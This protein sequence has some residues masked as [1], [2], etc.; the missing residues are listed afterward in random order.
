MSRVIVTDSSGKPILDR[1]HNFIA[2]SAP[3]VTDDASKGYS[4]GSQWIDQTAD[5]AYQCVDATT[6]AAVW[7]DLSSGGGGGEANTASNVG[8]TGTG[9]YD[10]KSGV[11][12]RFRKLNALSSKL[13]IAADA[14]NQKVD[15]DLGTV[16]FSDLSTK[17][18]THADA[19][20]GGTLDGAAIGAGTVAA[21]RLG[22]MTGD[23]GAGGA[24]G[25]V[26]APAAGDAA[27]GKYLKA[28][29]TWA[30]V[31]ATATQVDRSSGAAGDYVA[32]V[33]LTADSN[34]RLSTGLDGSSNPI[35]QLGAGGAS[36]LDLQLKRTAAKTLTLDD[37]A[38]GAATLTIA[39]TGTINFGGA[40]LLDV[41]N[42]K[43]RFPVASS[44]L[45]ATEGYIQ[46]RSDVDRVD[47]YDGQR[48]RSVTSRGYA[49]FAYP[50]VFDASVAFTTALALAAN[51]GSIAIPIFVPS[52]MLLE[53]VSVRNT[54]A[55]TARTWGWD[56]YEQY[57][58]NGNA[59][60]NTLTRVAAC[61]ANDTFTPGAASTRT[62][63]AG[64]APVYL[65]AGVY[66]LVVQSR[67]ATSTFGL[68]STAASGAFAVN[69]AQTKTTTNPNGA[70]LDLVAATWTKVTAI[71][72]VR[73]NG[74]VFGQTSAF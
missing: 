30:T 37:N 64:S 16:N 49:P 68:G 25:A 35:I 43:L 50:I 2:T 14:P 26:P 3:G 46:Y 72:A 69:S 45:T 67:H 13:T 24:K 51:G 58:N 61:S 17:T 59:G 4:V 36:A 48:D 29:G 42:A 31:A 53:S 73:L 33:K 70:T 27:A 19:A 11:D 66:W 47:V 15:I 62:L 18:H 65:G 74:R 28:D 5:I 38:A 6:G 55:A 32:R 10:S 56:L 22:L 52:N 7:K 20:N 40:G 63:T 9:F 44:G 60:E 12:L 23:A 39:S 1:K 34:Y 57:L 41:N 21:A 71:Y 54:D 8:T